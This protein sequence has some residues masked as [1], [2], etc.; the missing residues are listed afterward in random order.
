MN[1]KDV[2]TA[3]P[4]SIGPTQNLK[5]AKDMMLEHGIRHL[6]VLSHHRVVGVI[7]HR[8]I[9][10]ATAVD[11][12]PAEQI[13]IDTVY[14]EEPY[15]VTEDTPLV[16]VVDRMAKDGFGCAVVTDQH[17]ELTGIFTTTD[18]CRVLADRLK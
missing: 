12:K 13:R 1:V 2:M 6:P 4:H 3:C 8:D 5:V 17:G 16:S 14:N 7:S 15:T 18:A 11:Q 9:Y 10:F